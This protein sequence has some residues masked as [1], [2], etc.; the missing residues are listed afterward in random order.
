M[1]SNKNNSKKI[2]GNP[3]LIHGEAIEAMDRLIKEGITVDAIIT[4]PPYLISKPSGYTETNNDE[5]RKK[6]GKHSIDYGDWDKREI[7][8]PLLF[9]KYFR[10]LRN[11]GTLI[12]FYDVWKMGIIKEVAK[13]NN[14]KQ[15]RLG[16]WVK[17][18]P[19]PINSKL[20]YL[21]NAKEYFASFIKKAKPTFNSE[22][23]N[24]TYRY[25]IC[26]GNERTDHPTQKPLKLMEE[27]VIKHTS[28]GD[29]VL[30]PFMGS[31]TTGVACK[32]NN[33]GFIGIELN[34]NYFEIAKKRIIE[35]QTAKDLT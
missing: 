35:T 32:Q 30:D 12:T 22:Y 7:N 20:N 31:G 19:V 18:N 6:Y 16:V 15:P 33:R 4:D 9:E 8:L 25:P 5:Y 3:Q 14:F 34:E 26:S 13:Q 28:S 27:L 23:D 24:G 21:S 10:L 29:L 2:Q 1:S 17:T 11:G